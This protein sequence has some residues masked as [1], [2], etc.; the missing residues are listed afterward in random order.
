MMVACFAGNASKPSFRADSIR[1]FVGALRWIGEWSLA[2]LDQCTQ[3]AV[4]RSTS[5]DRLRSNAGR[6]TP[7]YTVPQSIP[8]MHLSKASPT[9]PID[10]AIPASRIASVN[11]IDAYWLPASL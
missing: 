9:L 10:P 2:V 6:S 7:T 5:A 11:A 1:A 4:S 3:E 8:S